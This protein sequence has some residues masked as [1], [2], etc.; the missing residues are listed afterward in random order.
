MP[1]MS[2]TMR[3]RFDG[4]PD[5]IKTR[6]TG[7]SDC[8]MS[9]LA[10]FS[11]KTQ[12][13]LRFDRNARGGGGPV[14]TGNLRSPFGVSR[15][16]HSSL[17]PARGCAGAST[18]STRANCGGA[19]RRCVRPCTAAGHWR[20]GPRSE[21]EQSAQDGQARPRPPLSCP[22]KPRGNGQCPVSR[23]PLAPDAF[24]GAR[25]IVPSANARFESRDHP[26]THRK[27]AERSRHGHPVRTRR[28]TPS[29]NRRL[30]LAVT[31]RS[32]F[33]PPT[34]AMRARNASAETVPSSFM[35][36]PALF[37]SCALD[38]AC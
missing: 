6:G 7:L 35:V 18:M 3:E 9:G 38:G 13:P 11:F 32:L 34:G 12:S 1:W 4:V 15:A 25:T 28:K 21:E 5:P 17:H 23:S 14:M 19:S 20:N 22:S 33:F 36:K 24:R 2:E 16:P 37:A 26:T 31:P 30:S 8:L 10:V 27:R 29:T